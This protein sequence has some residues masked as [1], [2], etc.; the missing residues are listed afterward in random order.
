M[1][2][3]G[4]IA[5][6]IGVL[7]LA[8]VMPARAEQFSPYRTQASDDGMAVIWSSV[9]V[10]L[11]IDDVGNAEAHRERTMSAFYKIVE[12]SYPLVLEALATRCEVTGVNSSINVAEQ[13]RQGA[14]LTL[15]GQITMKT[16]MKKNTGSAR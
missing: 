12:R 16:D 10:R 7:A 1:N 6:T 2:D 8:L 4:R 11:P 5:A 9:S 3:R 15:T 14:M 13:P